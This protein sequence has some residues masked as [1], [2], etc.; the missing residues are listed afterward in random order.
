MLINAVETTMGDGIAAGDMI[1]IIR[2]LFTGGNSGCFAYD[3]VTLD[4]E[5][6]SIGVSRDPFPA[7]ESNRAI[8]AIFDRYKIHEG[9]R[10]VR[11]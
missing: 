5:L 7:K 4:H 9:V 6:T 11:G 2:K 8:R 10:F 3:L 1:A